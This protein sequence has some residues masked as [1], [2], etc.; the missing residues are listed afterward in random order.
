MNSIETPV[1]T[2][3][4]FAN[5]ASWLV[6]SGLLLWGGFWA[7]FVIAAG[8][9]DMRAGLP[10]TLPVIIAWL[11]SLT[12]LIVVAWRWPRVG[13]LILI[14]A[15]AASAMYFRYPNTWVLLSLPPAI[16]GVANV[17]V[18]SCCRKGGKPPVSQAGRMPR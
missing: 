5:V 7:F 16:L 17:L 3:P 4:R 11:V 8:S 13:G 1:P 15:A 12:M 18:G 2:K 10:N 14:A 6:R 9:T